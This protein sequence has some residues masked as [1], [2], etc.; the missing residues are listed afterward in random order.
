VAYHQNAV[1]DSAVLFARSEGIIPAPEAAH[2]I[3][4][5]VDEA[6]RSREA[7]K[8]NVIA[9]NLS[10][11]GHFDMAA[12]DSY[13]EKGLEDYDL[14]QSQIDDALKNLPKTG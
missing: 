10:G 9:F 11:H 13:F 5:A 14:P 7:G 2:A 6:I 3:K 4:G 12:Y 8:S 1:F